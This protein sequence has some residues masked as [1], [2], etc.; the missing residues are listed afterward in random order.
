MVEEEDEELGL[1]V[2]WVVTVVEDVV[3]LECNLEDEDARLVLVLVTGARAE[4][5]LVRVVLLVA[6]AATAPGL[7][8][9][10]DFG[11]GPIMMTDGL[12]EQKKGSQ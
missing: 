7:F 8:L 4:A 3:D 2:E 9:C 10:N 11:G 6:L 5:L 12:P 1:E